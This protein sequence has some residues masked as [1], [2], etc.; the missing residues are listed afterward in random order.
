MTSNQKKKLIDTF[1]HDS[2]EANTF[3]NTGDWKRFKGYKYFTYLF[4]R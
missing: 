1:K 3:I 2:K 4:K